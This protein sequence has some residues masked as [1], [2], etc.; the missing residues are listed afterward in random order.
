MRPQIIQDPELKAHAN[1]E[2]QTLVFKIRIAILPKKK[3]IIS[4]D[5][6]GQFYGQRI[7]KLKAFESALPGIDK[8]GRPAMLPILLVATTPI[9]INPNES[10]Q[11]ALWAFSICQDNPKFIFAVSLGPGVYSHTSDI[12]CKNGIIAISRIT[13]ATLLIDISTAINNW[14]E[15]SYDPYQAII[16]QG[17]NQPAIF[18]TFHIAN[19]NTTYI[20]SYYGI[21][22]LPIQ[23]P[24]N[25]MAFAISQ[26]AA[27]S[28][29]KGITNMILK[30]NDQYEWFPQQ[31]F[32]ASSANPAIDS[33]VTYLPM[34]NNQWLRRQNLIEGITITKTDNEGNQT[35]YTTNVTVGHRNTGQGEDARYLHIIDQGNPEDPKE[36][37]KWIAPG[38]ILTPDPC[39]DSSTG[40]V[41]VPVG[42]DGTI[43]STT[44]YVIDIRNTANPVVIAEI[45]NLGR[46]GAMSCGI[47]HTSGYGKL[48]SVDLNQT[49]VQQ[50]H[51]IQQQNVGASIASISPVIAPIVRNSVQGGQSSL[52]DCQPGYFQAPTET[53]YWVTINQGVKRFL[54][55]ELQ[56]KYKEQLR[57]TNSLLGTDV[58]RD[59]ILEP[60]EIEHLNWGFKDK[61][62]IVANREALIQIQAYDGTTGDKEISIRIKKASSEEEP[63]IKPITVAK[64]TEDSASRLQEI[65]DIGDQFSGSSDAI[66]PAEFIGLGSTLE[67]LA[68]GVTVYGPVEIMAQQAKDLR[69]W[70]VSLVYDT[71]EDTY[72]LNEAQI[73]NFKSNL[74]SRLKAMTPIGQ[75]VQSVKIELLALDEP[76]VYE[77]NAKYRPLVEGNTRE[78]WTEFYDDFWIREQADGKILNGN[79]NIL[80]GDWL[81]LLLPAVNGHT[82]IS[83]VRSTVGQCDIG[84]HAPAV[85]ANLSNSIMTTIHEFGHGHGFLHVEVPDMNDAAADGGSSNF[86]YHNRGVIGVQAW[87]WENPETI[88]SSQTM[89]IM[90]YAPVRWLSD[91]HYERWW[92]NAQS[93]PVV[94]MDL[95]DPVVEIITKE[96]EYIADAS[97]DDINLIQITEPITIEYLVTDNRENPK[98]EV[99][100]AGMTNIYEGNNHRIS[101]TRQ[102]FLDLG[103]SGIVNQLQLVATPIDA[104]GNRGNTIISK[105]F[106]IED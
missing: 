6:S 84:K 1:P 95:I 38:P 49:V 14:I 15:Q 3:G 2:G 33:R 57:A 74:E 102:H 12:D 51:P 11:G 37:G 56:G 20:P 70:L 48:A 73:Q 91:Y 72:R 27:H 21:S 64:V 69:V 76:V 26:S 92:E 55:P 44:W 5:G 65:M 85:I 43:S 89:D 105:S 77:I 19:P 66:V 28:D 47:L 10:R 4:P 35:T 67:L 81:C 58:F 50:N 106:W 42:K 103:I 98:L 7:T 83:G 82:L 61:V 39:V 62:P 75:T 87:D 9:I 86:P 31:T 97:D 54:E 96:Y 78:R 100:F 34:E 36:L 60:N 101:V 8:E 99:K 68:D 13:S 30:N 104:A 32:I 41:A 22:L 88:L 90:T 16:P 23:P 18:Q 52:F 63:F 45:P 25:G 29:I 94:Q 71:G 53:K 79:S 40:Y 46:W 59:G 24:Q 93:I 17:A 80:H